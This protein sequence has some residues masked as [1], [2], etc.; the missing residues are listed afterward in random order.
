VTSSQTRDVLA[1]FER[2]ARADDFE[3]TQRLFYKYARAY[4]ALKAE[5]VAILEKIG[6]ERRGEGGFSK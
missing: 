5:F 2:A 1:R 3:Y 6:K 4:P